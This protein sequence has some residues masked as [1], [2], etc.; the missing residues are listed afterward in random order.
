MTLH[1]SEIGLWISR[2]RREWMHLN[3]SFV[4]ESC[5]L[6]RENKQI[7]SNWANQPRLNTWGANDQAQ[8]SILQPYYE[9]LPYWRWF[10]RWLGKSKN[11]G[12]QWQ[13]GRNH[14]LHQWMHHWGTWNTRLGIDHHR[15]YLGTR[16]D[17]CLMVKSITWAS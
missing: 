1:G 5:G 6:W 14:L 8:I 17:N 15:E 13:C 3:F 12:R 16:I 4:E 9:D 7:K 2:I 10:P 11:R